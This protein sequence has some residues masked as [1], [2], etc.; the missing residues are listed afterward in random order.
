VSEGNVG[1]GQ[2]GARFRSLDVLFTAT[3]VAAAGTLAL[4]I[5]AGLTHRPMLLWLLPLVVLGGYLGADFLSGLVHWL[6]DTYGSPET[7]IVGPKFVA[8][9]REHHTDPTA[10]TRHD[11]L[12]ANGDNCLAG[13]VCLAPALLLPVDSE[14]W[15]TLSGSWLLVIG[16]STSLTAM[17]HG[18][19]HAA[20]PAG[21][22]RFLQRSGLV[23]SPDHHEVH[24]TSPHKK[25]YCITTGWLNPLLDRSRFFRRLE[26]LLRR[27]GMEPSS[28][29][30]AERR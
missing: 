28:A 10:I 12:E 11:F 24:H 30:K 3:F 26:S 15:A 27:F 20:R 7:P 19:A 17:V 22:I 14:G 5:V 1:H 18:W 16:A 13:A 29:A 21:W 25:H 9:F 2:A 8:P 4:E 6:A 23:L